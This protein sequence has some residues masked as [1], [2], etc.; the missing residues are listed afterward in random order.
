MISNH[1]YWLLNKRIPKYIKP[2]KGDGAMLVTEDKVIHKVVNVD[3][4][5]GIKMGV[6]M[7]TGVE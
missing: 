2:L 1:K 4:K 5:M 7:D 3:I 6:K